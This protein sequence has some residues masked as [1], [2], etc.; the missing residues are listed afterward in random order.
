ML[1]KVDVVLYINGGTPSDE[2]WY[3]TY[4]SWMASGFPYKDYAPVTVYV[5]GE[6]V[7]EIF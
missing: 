2:A 7:S 1:Q 6:I 3:S 4:C 5:G